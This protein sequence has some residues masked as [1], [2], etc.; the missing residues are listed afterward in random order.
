MKVIWQ[1]PA[2]VGK[3]QVST[4]IRREFSINRAKIFKQE[5]A[6]TINTLMLSPYIGKIDPLFESHVFTYRSIVING[7]SKLVYRVDG[8]TIYIVAFWDTRMEPVVQAAKVR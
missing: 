3:R 6:D 4:Y 8:D 7:L 2:K 5:V 1:E